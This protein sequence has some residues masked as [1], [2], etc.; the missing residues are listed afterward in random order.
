M[1]NI[2]LKILKP[3]Y[4][5]FD[6]ECCGICHPEGLSIYYNDELI[7]EK[8]SD[9]HYS[10][11]QTEDSILNTILNKWQ[12][13]SHAEILL[14]SSEEKRNNYNLT[15]PGNSIA[16]TPESW[17]EYHNSTKE[18]INTMYDIFQEHCTHL[19]SNESLQVKMIALWLEEELDH[20]IPIIELEK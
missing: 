11:H 14:A 18:Y 10:S 9:D 17:A 16:K 12:E 3:I 5:S 1:H 13:N 6:C 19:P 4:K 15:S 8:Y 20:K 2:T 7:W